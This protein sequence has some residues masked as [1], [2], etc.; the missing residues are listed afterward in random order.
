MTLSES[1]RREILNKVDRLVATKFYDPAFKGRNWRLIVEKHEPTVIAA[2]DQDAFETSINTILGELGSSGLGLISASTKIA[3]K[4]SIS[5]T[6]RAVETDRDTRWVFQDVHEGGPAAAAGIASGHVLM[7]IGDHE[8]FPPE[9]PAFPMGQRLAVTVGTQSGVKK[10][11]IFTPDAKHKENPCAVPASLKTDLVDGGRVVKIPLFPGKLGIAFARELST[12]FDTL[13]GTERLVLDFRGNPGGG[14][15]GLRVMSLM[16]PDRR[17]VGFSVDRK[18]AERGFDKG[19]FPKFR[20]IPR[21]KFE[22]PLLALRFAGKKYVVLV[23]EGLGPKAFHGRI[24]VL[25][26]EHTTC[27]SEMVALFATSAFACCT[28]TFGFRWPIML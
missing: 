15:G 6:F 7:A 28:V 10:L 16:V 2:K 3:P 5:A 27:A 9:R 4:N 20:R 17:P 26:N 14:I 23:T 11:A 1:Q 25:L 24:V 22:V 21:S 13:N 18:T 12:A 19:T 8:I